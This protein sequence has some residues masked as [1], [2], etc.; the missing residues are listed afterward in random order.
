MRLRHIEV[1]YALMKSRNMTEAAQR[2]HVSQ[3][4]VSMVLKHAEQS[5]KLKL[6]HRASGRLIP[7]PEAL[8]L[9]PE[10]EEIF[11]RLEALDRYALGIRTASAGTITVAAAPT[12]ASFVLPPLISSF[13]ADRPQARIALRVLSSSH[14]Q[15][16]VRERQSDF[17]VIY[18]PGIAVD[19]TLQC[20][21]IHKANVV[22]VLPRNHLLC[23]QPFVTPKDLSDHP[24]VTFGTASELG[25]Q[26]EASFVAAGL[27]L[28]LRLESSSSQSSI[29]LAASGLGAALVESS[30][31][32]GA[33]PNLVERDFR[34]HIE[35][36]IALLHRSDSP[37]SRLANEFWQYMRESLQVGAG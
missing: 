30:G 35:T 22:C 33:F 37:K 20:E 11:E 18:Q 6:F 25:A 7:T 14:V 28:N 8:A 9:L 17:G 1:F 29:F 3:P 16:S 36:R 12:V 13:T 26:I 4:A 21:L 2:L 34:P 32:I 31:M 5:L 10:V 27:A 24:L 23:A 15:A 19:E